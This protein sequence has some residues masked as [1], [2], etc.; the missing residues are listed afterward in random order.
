[1]GAYGERQDFS[2]FA[3]ANLNSR[4]MA[5]KVNTRHELVT[6]LMKWAIL[7]VDG[8]QARPIYDAFVVFKVSWQNSL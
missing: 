1:M 5:A 8:L 3:T 7:C 4:M 6:F 2:N